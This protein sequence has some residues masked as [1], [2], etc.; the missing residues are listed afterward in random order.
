MHGIE[1]QRIEVKFAEPITGI[2][3]KKIAHIVARRAVEIERRSPRR[4]IAVGEIGSEVGKV[5]HLRAEMIVDNIENDRQ[6]FAMAGVDQA[7]ER[8][9]PAVGVLDGEWKD[10][11]VT[12]ISGAGKLTDRH[13]L[14]RGDA[15]TFEAREVHR[16]RIEAA[17]LGV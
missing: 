3:E 16:N 14:E 4:A 1:A 15:E 13:E 8:S 5:I 12:P 10:A 6:T 2:L 17:A 11:V 9:G 7:L